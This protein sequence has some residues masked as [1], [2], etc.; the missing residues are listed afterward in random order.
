[1]H[2][3]GEMTS[4]EILERI[5]EKAARVFLQTTVEET[6][7]AVQDLLNFITECRWLYGKPGAKPVGF[8]SG[9]QGRRD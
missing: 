5:Y 2:N 6:T 9:T 7:Q 1:M 3:L 4:D 8:V